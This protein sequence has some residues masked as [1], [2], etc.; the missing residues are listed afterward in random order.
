VQFLGELLFSRDD[1]NGG[2]RDTPKPQPIAPLA[3]IHRLKHFIT[4]PDIRVK[5]REF[6][7]IH[8]RFDRIAATALRSSVKIFAR[9]PY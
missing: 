2:W 5:P 1:R 8:A 4:D 7:S 3:H 9:L 6:S